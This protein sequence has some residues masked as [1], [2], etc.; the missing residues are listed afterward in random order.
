MLILV[1]DERRK[2]SGRRRKCVSGLNPWI[3]LYRVIMYR[4]VILNDG[5]VFCVFYF[6]M[7]DDTVCSSC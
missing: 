4:N 1:F 3:A 6:K 7:D 5:F 2:H